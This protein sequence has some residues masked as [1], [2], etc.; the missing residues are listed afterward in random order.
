[1]RNFLGVR[2]THKKYGA[3]T[4]SV[5]LGL[6]VCSSAFAAEQTKTVFK[7]QIN[8]TVYYS[9]EYK[10]ANVWDSASK[11]YKFTKDSTINAKSI[12]GASPINI[13]AP[14]VTLTLNSKDE[15]G[16][17]S[18]YG[19]SFRADH[20][21]KKTNDITITAKKVVINVDQIAKSGSGKETFGI[22]C[23]SDNTKYNVP[24][25]TVTV[26]GDVDITVKNK[27]YKA[28]DGSGEQDP[29]FTNGIATV[30]HGNIVV[31]G[32][33][34]VHV[35]VPEQ[36]QD[37]P[38]RP[39]K[40]LSHYYVNGIFAGLNYDEDKPGSTVTI[41]G[42]VDV[43]VDGTGVH[44]GARSLITIGGGGTIRT[45]QD[46]PLPHFALNA[47]EGT[48]HMNVVRDSAGNVTGA[49][50]RT[51]KVYGN[52]ALISREDG[53]TT[54]GNAPTTINLGLTTADSVLHG[55]VLDDFKENDPTYKPEKQ[56][57]RE[58]T[59]LNLYLQNGAT[60]H[61]SKWGTLPTGN[62][63]GRTHDFTGSKLR[64]LIGG[65]T[66][67][68]A[69]TIHQEDDRP[70][71]I[72]NYSGYTNLMYKHDA[73]NPSSIIGGDIVIKK[74]A[75]NSGI[76]LRTD[77][78]GLNPG[79]KNPEERGKVEATLGALAQKLY[80]TAY[81]NGERNL[82]GQVGIAEGLTTSAATLRLEDVNYDAAT[83]QGKFTPSAV[84]YGANETAIM[85]GTKTGL[86]TG[87]LLWSGNN[88]DLQRRMGEL[89][90]GSTERGAWVKYFGGKS[91]IDQ[92]NIDMDLTRHTVQVGYDRDVRDWTVGAA[93]D[94]GKMS[95]SY[96]GGHADGRM[97]SLA[98]YGAQQRKDGSYLDLIAHIG[99]MHGN[100]TASNAAVTLSGSQKAW[101]TSLSAEYGK[102]IP[103]HG[104]FYIEP[105]AELTF[106]RL[107]GF[108]TVARGGGN[109]LNI[110]QDAF[111]SV[112][113]RLNIGIG[114]ETKKSNLFAR[115]G[116]SHEFAGGFDT[117]YHEEG[118]APK[119]THVSLKETWLNMEL[120]GSV[121]LSDSSYVY[122]NYTRTLNSDLNKQWRMDAGVRF[123]F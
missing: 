81:Q 13:S 69:G 99:R 120:G 87:A 39:P 113:G 52:I 20:N 51:T 95:A 109:T 57:V 22:V 75:P 84:T 46:T 18:Y 117:Q 123:S 47:E 112:V 9:S 104:G 6:S 30:H 62:W 65:E 40:F 107:Q 119:A 72:E 23:G 97:G 28:P 85:R 116:L 49:G 35:R 66:P 48:I 71:S 36:E 64:A 106:G 78:A 7:D 79:S 92:P 94:Y 83:G 29:T 33:A 121:R 90:L 26:N 27:Y 59:G 16:I 101:G 37:S 17:Q 55:V 102:R 115:L 63:G 98:L 43:D 88:N 5:L 14:G 38:N 114:Q 67:E 1:M 32:N 60:W 110:H 73:A 100:Y 108:D 74:A 105:S 41:G 50:T 19:R 89:R 91:S 25:S 31:N 3:L 82:K 80:Y 24:H 2:M 42:D 44:A 58:K 122:A 111:N 68:K 4:L 61:N 56:A 12:T 34:K 10:R 118:Y 70:I 15:Y 93:F 86:L 76:T 103:Q 77:N 21:Y 8:G 53:K 54:P 45:K 11:T 96:S